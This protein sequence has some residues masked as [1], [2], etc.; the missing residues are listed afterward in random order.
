MISIINKH[1]QYFMVISFIK[2]KNIIR[3]YT[4]KNRLNL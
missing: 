3:Y 2:K 1:I 4:L